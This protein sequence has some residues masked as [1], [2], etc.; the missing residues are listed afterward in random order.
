MNQDEP[1]LKRGPFTPEEQR[2]I[3]NYQHSCMHAYTCPVH[4]DRP[5]YVGCE[6]LACNDP[7]CGYIQ[8]E[9]LLAIADGRMQEQINE[10]FKILKSFKNEQ[11]R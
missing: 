4:A 2:N 7:Q 11:N 8:H 9:V 6:Y 1:E 3:I 5:L 10:V